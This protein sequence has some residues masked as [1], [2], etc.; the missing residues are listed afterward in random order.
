MDN[1]LILGKNAIKAFMNQKRKRHDEYQK[2]KIKIKLKRME[3]DLERE[4][5]REKEDLDLEEEW[6][7]MNFEDE[8]GEEILK[9]NKGGL[10]R[11]LNE[12]CEK[13]EKKINK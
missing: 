9:K 6:R 1:L 12:K 8:F 7:I 3:E 2:K 13:I 11:A 10:F 4:K 5:E